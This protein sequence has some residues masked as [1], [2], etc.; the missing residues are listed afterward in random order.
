[1]LIYDLADPQELQ[2]FVRGVQ[3]ER[4]ENDFVLSQFL[5]NQNIDELEWRITQ[6]EFRD[7]DVAPY[8]AWDTEA[9]IGGRQG[10]RRLMGELPPLSK[11]YQ[12]GEE[13]RLRRRM[14]DRGG[15]NA[16]L[17][18]IIFDD[19]AKGARSVSARLELARGEVLF[20]AALDLRT[21][22]RGGIDRINQDAIDFERDPSHS[23]A[24]ATPWS[25]H[26]VNAL[27]EELAWRTTYRTTNGID[28]GLALVSET[29][30][31]H[32]LLNEQY[33][34]LAT[35]N[36]I[37]PAFLNLAQ[38]NQVR[39]AHRLP[40]LVAYDTKVRV[41][42]I[43]IRVTPEDKM[44]YLPPAGQPLGRTF[45]GTTAEALELAE[46]NQIATDQIP[47]MTAVVEKTFDP[48]ATWTKVSAIAIPTLMN[49]DL[50]LVA[51]VL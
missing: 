36:G 41:E 39:S 21:F 40:P 5:P 35:Y 32:L 1:M 48:V 44:L 22:A 34:E 47:G 9:A 6:G 25:N 4:D 50:T 37:T 20:T 30:I 18:R 10:V 33:R 8:R 7:E 42:G 26:S 19:A 51:D 17:V 13:A 45:S 49:P 16:E 24:A 27:T 38:L 12:L 29:I 14:L 11:K 3:R 43:H 28:P 23:V 2:G 46:A 15:D 31:T